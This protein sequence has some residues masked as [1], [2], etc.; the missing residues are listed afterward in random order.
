MRKIVIIVGI[1]LF[2]CVGIL[3]LEHYSKSNSVNENTDNTKFADR[4]IQIE[5]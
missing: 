2:A 1:I 5:R 3:T 4:T